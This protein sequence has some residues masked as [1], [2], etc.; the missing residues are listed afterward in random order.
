ME[1]DGNL[2]MSPLG[3]APE[4]SHHVIS[5]PHPEHSPVEFASGVG[6]DNHEAISSSD[7]VSKGLVSEDDWDALYSL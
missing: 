4:G 1:D 7:I 2:H 3:G 5:L 6:I